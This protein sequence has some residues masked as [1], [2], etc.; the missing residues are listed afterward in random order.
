MRALSAGTFTPSSV[1]FSSSYDPYGVAL[2]QENN[3]TGQPFGYTGAY[4]D[5]EAQFHYLRA[6][7]YNPRSG[8]F[9]E[10]DSVL[11]ER[12]APNSLNRYI[13]AQNNPLAYQDPSGHWVDPW[14]SWYPASPL[15]ADEGGSAPPWLG[16]LL[17][18]AAAAQAA[19]SGAIQQVNP[20]IVRFSQSSISYTFR[21]GPFAGQ[22]VDD[23]A[24]AMREAGGAP[25]GMP[26][27][28]LVLRYGQL[29]TLDNRR[30]FAARLAGVDIPFVM[31]T[32]EE[33]ENFAWHFITQNMGL[34]IDV[35]G[36]PMFHLFPLPPASP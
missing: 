18:G 26:P 19:M 12:Q 32:E 7:W 30:L 2:F 10:R 17:T 9:I 36:A 14:F 16:P 4:Y 22:T 11:G 35:L 20:W 13:Y 3:G 24:Q 25:E 33:A 1:L 27:I 8:R 5:P 15:D 23:L 29:F 28:R 34:S 31:A 6:R 21:R